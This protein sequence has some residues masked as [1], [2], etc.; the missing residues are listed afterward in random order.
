MTKEEM[1]KQINEEKNEEIWKKKNM[2][3]IFHPFP[4]TRRGVGDA[5]NNH[6]VHYGGGVEKDFFDQKILLY[7]D[8]SRLS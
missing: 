2:K 3:R 4:G 8:G 6:L 5:I 1:E 7:L